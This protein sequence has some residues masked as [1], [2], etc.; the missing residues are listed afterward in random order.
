[1][2]QLQLEVAVLADVFFLDQDGTTVAHV[3][4]GGTLA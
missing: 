4:R 1:L 3:A 2:E